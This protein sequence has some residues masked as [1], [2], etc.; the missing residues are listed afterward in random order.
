ML[1]CS[2]HKRFL[3]GNYTR[4]IAA[5]QRDFRFPPSLKGFFFL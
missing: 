4:F 1:H 2:F 5:P 3:I